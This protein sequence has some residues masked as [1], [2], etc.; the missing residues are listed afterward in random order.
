MR[1]PRTLAT[2]MLLLGLAWVLVM[3]LCSCHRMWV[4]VHY[5]TGNVMNAEA[6]NGYD[7]G[8][9]PEAAR[10]SRKQRLNCAAESR[11]K[12]EDRLTDLHIEAKTTR[13]RV[14][15]RT[16]TDIG[17]TLDLFTDLTYADLYQ[18]AVLPTANTRRPCPLVRVKQCWVCFFSVLQVLRWI[19]PPRLVTGLF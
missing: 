10:D 9:G 2:W 3:R 6:C 13:Q 19:F 7:P 14:D 15:R 5:N 11:I 12:Q 8:S 1:R 16:K 17:T 4:G 18:I